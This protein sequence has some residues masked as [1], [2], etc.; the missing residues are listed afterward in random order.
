M[1]EETLAF[2]LPDSRSNSSKLRSFGAVI[3]RLFLCIRRKDFLQG[4]EDN[5][6]RKTAAMDFLQVLVMMF[7]FYLQQVSLIILNGINYPQQWLNSVS[8]LRNVLVPEINFNLGLQDGVA[9]FTAVFL[10]PIFIHL[11]IFVACESAKLRENT[12]EANPKPRIF[13]SYKTIFFSLIFLITAVPLSILD[14]EYW[15]LC[16]RFRHYYK[17]NIW[18]AEKVAN[19]SFPR[20]ARYS[21]WNFEIQVYSVLSASSLTPV[22]SITTNLITDNDNL[23]ITAVFSV[24]GFSIVLFLIIF[25]F[26]VFKSLRKGEKNLKYIGLVGKYPPV[27]GFYKNLEGYQEQFKWLQ[28]LFLAEK[29]ALTT[30][31]KVFNVEEDGINL[32]GGLSSLAIILFVYF[33]L[34]VR[35]PY[36]NQELNQIDIFTRL[37]NVILLSTAL[38]FTRHKMFS[39][40]LANII[41]FSVSTI[42]LLYWIYV[43]REIVFSFQ[44]WLDYF[45]LFVLFRALKKKKRTFE[46]KRMWQNVNTVEKATVILEKRAEKNVFRDEWEEFDGDKKLLV[47]CAERNEAFIDSQNLEEAQD[48]KFILRYLESEVFFETVLRTGFSKKLKIVELNLG[49]GGITSK[50]MSYILESNL[51][52]KLPYLNYFEFSGSSISPLAAK[53]LFQAMLEGNCKAKRIHFSENNFSGKNF[54]VLCDYLSQNMSLEYFCLQFSPNIEPE[55]NNLLLESLCLKNFITFEFTEVGL[56]GK[57]LTSLIKLLENAPRLERFHVSRNKLDKD[58]LISLY[59]V[60]SKLRVNGKLDISVYNQQGWDEDEQNLFHLNEASTTLARNKKLEFSYLSLNSDM[61]KYKAVNKSTKKENCFVFVDGE[62]VGF[63][64]F[65]YDCAKDGVTG[66]ITAALS[67][68]SLE[69]KAQLKKNFPQG[70]SAKEA[71]SLRQLVEEKGRYRVSE[72]LNALDL[73]FN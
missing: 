12:T 16:L 51:F 21:F 24:V 72:T 42:T 54:D 64:E 30:S 10:F 57:N 58:C 37:S 5:A 71:V 52:E 40:D 41:M 17:E 8:W 65:A 55:A 34:Y 45:P 44:A 48:I 67:F 7:V 19:G 32:N 28:I 9:V 36:V 13:Y 56:T 6:E 18:I 46:I 53:N 61:G 27:S 1:K 63:S 59:E 29:I 43:F 3:A 25:Y 2:A 4:R 14:V 31:S 50:G 62:A 66:F 15:K 23:V 73:I 11:L 60:F 69:E 39:E 26:I 68:L 35:L 22:V 38:L 70:S 33:I 20:F 47:L 49:F